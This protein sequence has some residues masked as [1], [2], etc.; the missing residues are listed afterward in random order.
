MPDNVKIVQISACCDS[1]RDDR[2]YGLGDD[3]NPYIWSYGDL[4]KWIHIF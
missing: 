2:I 3:G 1:E 4:N